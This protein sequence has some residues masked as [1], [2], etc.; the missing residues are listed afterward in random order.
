MLP[1]YIN[2]TY[3]NATRLGFLITA[4]GAGA[5]LG[6]ILYGV[7]GHRL[8]RHAIFV[9]GFAGMGL[10]TLGLALLPPFIV[11]LGLMALMGLASGP[12]NP[13]IW[14]VLQ[15]RTPQEFRARV[16]GTVMALAIATTP[17]GMLLAGYL[18]EI[19]GVQISLAL[20]AACSVVLAASL[21]VNPALSEL[22]AVPR[23]DADIPAA[24]RDTA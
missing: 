18:L 7:I 24:L 4:F 21:F 19:W 14:T 6:A 2:T 20:I 8:P 10:L 1:V 11:L 13:M 3:G 17:L 22:N 5:V 15:E 16:F 23:A 12:L 9:G